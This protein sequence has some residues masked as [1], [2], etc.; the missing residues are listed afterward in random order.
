MFLTPLYAQGPPRD[1][2]PRILALQ[3]E[4][5]TGNRVAL[6]KFWDE[7]VKQGTPLVEPALN[8]DNYCL[9]TFLWRGKKEVKGAQLISDLTESLQERRP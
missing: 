4:L 8:S 1:T 6:E 3:R 9:V 7:I 2:S 5:E